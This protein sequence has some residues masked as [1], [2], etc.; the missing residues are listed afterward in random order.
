MAD[1]RA[2]LPLWLDSI[3]LGHQPVDST[4][5]FKISSQHN[6]YKPRPRKE[7]ELERRERA[8]MDSIRESAN[9]MENLGTSAD[10]PSKDT[11]SGRR[12]SN[13]LQTT[14]KRE[15]AVLTTSK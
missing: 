4:Q 15:R 11:K 5:Y 8:R 6:Y 1:R 14:G 3:A 12:P 2:D 13:S 7:L 10:S 9:Q